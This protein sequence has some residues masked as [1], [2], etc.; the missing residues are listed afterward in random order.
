MSETF[1]E[2]ARRIE[3]DLECL[4]QNAFEAFCTGW[5]G[6]SPVGEAKRK[7]VAAGRLDYVKAS[8]AFVSAVK[9]LDEMPS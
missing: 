3:I 2:R 7:L 6:L 8:P 9:L 5:R 1:E 4:D